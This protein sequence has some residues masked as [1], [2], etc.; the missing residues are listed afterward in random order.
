MGRLSIII[1][2]LFLILSGC[3]TNDP[4]I[5]PLDTESAHFTH[6]LPLEVVASQ[7]HASVVI[8]TPT[9]VQGLVGTSQYRMSSH[10]LHLGAMQV[11]DIFGVVVTDEQQEQEPQIDMP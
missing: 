2:G 9:D 7:N 10:S 8:S 1:L 6:P 5:N 3:D 11:N 4:L